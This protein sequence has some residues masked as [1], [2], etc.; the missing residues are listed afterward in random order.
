MHH[1]HYCYF[2]KLQALHFMK[3][4]AAYWEKSYSRISIFIFRFTKSQLQM[5]K[6]WSHLL[7]DYLR[8]VE[9]GSSSFMFKIMK[10]MIPNLMKDLIWPKLQQGSW[11]RM[12]P[13]P[14]LFVLLLITWFY[15]PLNPTS[16]FNDFSKYRKYG[17]EDDTIDFIGHA[18]ALHLDDNYLDLPAKDFVERVKVLILQNQFHMLLHNV[19]DS[20]LLKLFP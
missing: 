19:K 6:H 5:L 14:F 2:S 1:I 16:V 12:Y 15:I 13:L 7:W 18:L 10:Q 8:S 4:P 9:L 3:P 11:Y 20:Q 17:L